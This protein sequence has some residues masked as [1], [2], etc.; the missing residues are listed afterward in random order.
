MYDYI[1][2]N[3]NLA[4]QLQFPQYIYQNFKDYKFEKYD[5]WKA[6]VIDISTGLA[7]CYL[8]NKDYQMAKKIYQN[9]LDLIPQLNNINKI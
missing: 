7:N 4:K 9:S 2:F 6:E 8:Q 5:I 3:D 1:E